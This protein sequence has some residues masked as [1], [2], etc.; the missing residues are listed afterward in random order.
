[1][2]VDCA[3]GTALIEVDES[4]QN[5]IVVIPGA[6]NALLSELIPNEAFEQFVENGI[7]LAQL[8]NPIAELEKLFLR[9]KSLGQITIL[10]PAPAQPLP[11]SFAREIDILI[12]NEY[13][14]SL[15]T[16]IEVTDQTSAAAAGR[17]LLEM[18]IE[19]VVITLGS[20]GALLVT[21]AEIE[22][23]PAFDVNPID[24]TAA[25]DVFCGALA[26]ELSRGNT[27]KDSI[28]FAC[29]AGALATTKVGATL[30]APTYDAVISLISAQR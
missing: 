14:A 24:T 13:E 12:P 11:P 2:T 6:N 16:G 25:G 26:S 4:G 23:F 1:L 20:K 15:L 7:V 29:A 21:E 30:S 28:Q 27:L 18:G 8:E 17:K 3:C 22:Y 19:T 5:R 9:A 10:N